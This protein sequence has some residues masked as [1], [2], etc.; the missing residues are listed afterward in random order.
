MFVDNRSQYRISAMAVPHGDTHTV[1]FATFRVA[2]QVTPGGMVP[3]ELLPVQSDS[4]SSMPACVGTSWSLG[5]TAVTSQPTT[6]LQAEVRVT[7]RAP[8]GVRVLG[9]RVWR[10]DRGALAPS[11][12]QPFE[13]MSL[14]CERAFGG[15][16][17]LPPGERAGLPHPALR[18]AH[19]SNPRGRG[20]FVDAAS[21][22]GK[23]CHNLEFADAPGI[24]WPEQ[25]EAA[26]LAPDDSQLLSR[27]AGLGGE[28][29]R[30]PALVASRMCHPGHARSFGPPLRPGDSLVAPGF[31]PGPHFRC[32]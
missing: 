19:P 13:R 23:P 17:E 15:T 2:Y 1:G 8:V 3:G 12:P 20:Y 24:V 27:L 30:E 7:G 14:G 5:G 29:E 10:R 22:E 16:I 21:A 26:V 28:I 4:L 32:D 25:P 11:T 18:L 9:E 6:M 31:R